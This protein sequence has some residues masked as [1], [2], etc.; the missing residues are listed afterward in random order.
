MIIQVQYKT[1]TKTY[2][3]QFPFHFFFFQSI[4][5]KVKT[6]PSLVHRLA[7]RFSYSSPILSKPFPRHIAHGQLKVRVCMCLYVQY[8]T[9]KI[10]FRIIQFHTIHCILSTRAE[11]YSSNKCGPEETIIPGH[12]NYSHS[13]HC[14]YYYYYRELRSKHPPRS[15]HPLC[16]LQ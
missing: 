5:D 12:Y 8:A 15:E 2:F 6:T 14:H 7:D 1:R 13:S 4:K 3:L 10:T 11:S 16:S 9:F